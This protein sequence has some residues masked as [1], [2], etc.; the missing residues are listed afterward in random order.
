MAIK[1]FLRDTNADTT[2]DSTGPFDLSQTQGTPGV[3]AKSQNSTGT[4]VEQQSFDVDVSGDTPDDGTIDWSF[5]INAWSADASVRIRIQ[6]VDDTGCAVDGSTAYL[7]TTAGWD[8]DTAGTGVKTGSIGSFTWPSTSERLRVSVEVERDTGAHGSKSVTFNVNDADSFIRMNGFGNIAPTVQAATAASTVLDAQSGTGV[9]PIPPQVQAATAA[10]IIADA[11][12]AGAVMVR[13]VGATL[14]SIVVSAATA[15]ALTVSLASASSASI[16]LDAQS[17]TNALPPQVQAAEAA[18]IRIG[19]ASA[20]SADHKAFSAVYTVAAATS[21]GT[22]DLTLSGLGF[23]PKA[24]IITASSDAGDGTEQTDVQYCIGMSDGTTTKAKAVGIEDN[25]S[26]NGDATR[27]AQNDLIV[28]PGATSPAAMLGRATFTS[29]IADGVRVNWSVAPPSATQLHI[30]V[31]GGDGLLAHVDTEFSNTIETDVEVTGAGFTPDAIVTAAVLNGTASASIAYLTVGM[32]STAENQQCYALN[33]TT[34]TTTQCA[35]SQVRPYFAG[36][37][38]NETM[39][40]FAVFSHFTDDGFVYDRE[41]PGS[42]SFA[43]MLLAS[44][45]PI[46]AG[47]Y[48]A[49]TSP[50]TSQA[51]T[52]FGFR[53]QSVFMWATPFTTDDTGSTVDPE[54]IALS[55]HLFDADRAYSINIATEDAA[56]PTDAWTRWD[57]QALLSYGSDRTLHQDAEFVSFD[58]DGFTLNYSTGFSGQRWIVL[59]LAGDPLPQVQAA[60]AA[61]IALDT[62][63]ATGVQGAAPQ[64]QAASAASTILDAQSAGSLKATTRAAAAGAISLEASS[65]GVFLGRLSRAAAAVSIALDAATA[66]ATGTQIVAASAAGLAVDAAS[67]SS[68]TAITGSASASSTSLDAQSATASMGAVSRAATSAELTLDAASATGSVSSSGTATAAELA[69]DAQAATA[70]PGPL[71]RA[72]TAASTAL[73]A[74]AASSISTLQ[75]PATAAA[76]VVDALA[77]SALTSTSGTATAAETSLD[78]ASGSGIVG[79]VSQAATSAGLSLDAATGSGTGA[80]QQGASAAL[81]ALDAASG[82]GVTGSVTRPA[83]AA[84]TS[85]DAA[86]AGAQLATSVSATAAVLVA[87]ASTA[88][89]LTAL[90]ESASSAEISLDTASGTGVQP[91]DGQAVAAELSLDAQSAGF[92]ATVTVAATASETVLDARSGSGSVSIPPIVRAATAASVALDAPSADPVLVR[93]QAATAASTALDTASGSGVVGSLSRG[94][95]AASIALNAATASATG[96]QQASATAASISLTAS[97]ASNARS[98]GA[99]A[100]STALD[101]A[102]AGATLRTARPATAASISLDVGTAQDISTPPVSQTHWRAKREVPATVNADAT[103]RSWRVRREVDPDPTV[104]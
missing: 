49:P 79:P 30:Q 104:G 36:A 32:A 52:G 74:S 9:Q 8:T 21:T 29:F 20:W 67:G 94:A 39:N 31:F 45:R 28:I 88:G 43:Y 101:T 93:V 57:S 7:P 102:S 53:P 66:S 56:D 89:A 60:T 44:A 91:I 77:A 65:D 18:S 100:A 81:L 82:T 68:L 75:A 25:V 24:V 10:S 76:L 33:G 69:L 95:T 87:D 40:T 5:D 22:Q 15:A 86:S 78:A 71:T 55:T 70:S 96:A 62:P 27:Y 17:G 51:H 38:I 47:G 99:T 73:D 1:Y 50:T 48:D 6:A 2:C 41:G 61:S 97:S 54:S 84:V 90:S 46:Y 72:A 37:G 58:A 98:I 23:T 34:S 80:Q 4:W 85:L 92:I 26:T 19:A 35:F 13:R 11:A 103:K 12:S 83:T 3:T 14:A 63:S 64:V 42:H 16:T 59:A